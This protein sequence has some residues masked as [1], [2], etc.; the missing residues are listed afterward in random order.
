MGGPHELADPALA[1]L[2]FLRAVALVID[3][4]F[5]YLLLLPFIVGIAVSTN[6]MEILNVPALFSEACWLY[7]AL[8]FTATALL[9]FSTTEAI[10]GAGVG[11]GVMGLRVTG[12]NGFGRHLL[13]N[14]SKAHLAL[15]AVDVMAGWG[16]NAPPGFRA[17]ERIAGGE[18]REVRPPMGFILRRR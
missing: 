4:A 10:W 1:R 17:L 16:S 3:Y 8:L 13:R 15:L 2:L 14:L 11:K 12:V 6:V 18:V 5:L 9:Y 7:L